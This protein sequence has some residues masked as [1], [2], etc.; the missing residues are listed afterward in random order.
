MNRTLTNVRN[1]GVVPLLGRV[2]A[3]CGTSL[4]LLPVTDLL[5]NRTEHSLVYVPAYLSLKNCT[6][7]PHCVFMCFV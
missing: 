1:G 6:F 5:K 7:C 2:I 4:L 3:A